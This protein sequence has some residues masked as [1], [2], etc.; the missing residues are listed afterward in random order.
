MAQ[1]KLRQKQESILSSCYQKIKITVKGI[2]LE[3]GY[4][5]LF[6]LRKDDK[7]LFCYQTQMNDITELV[8]LEIIK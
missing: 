8:I 7:S 1:E 6:Y 5:F 4:D 2:A 3:K